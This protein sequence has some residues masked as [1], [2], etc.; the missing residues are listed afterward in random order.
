M[1][2][3]APS[4]LTPEEEE[5]R[6]WARYLNEGGEGLRD[7]IARVCPT[8][9]APPHLTPLID[10]MERC[11]L[12]GHQ[13]LAVSFPPRHGKTVT[14]RRALAWWLKARPADCC[15]Y[16]SRTADG[17]A[18]QSR[19]V[20]FLAMA[21]G[22]GLAKNHQ[23]DDNWQTT[24]GGGLFACGIDGMLTGNPITGLG[25]VDD[26]IKSRAEAES[27]AYR[28]RVWDFF[29]DVVMTRPEGPASIIVVHTR[30][31][32]DDLI[33]RLIQEGGWDVINL[34]AIA[35]QGDPIGRQE[36]EA[37]WPERFPVDRLLKIKQ[38]NEF[39]FDSLYQ[40]RPVPKGN[41]LFYGPPCYYDPKKT[42]LKGCHVLI[43]ADPAATAKTTAD[44]SAAV[45][46]AIRP[47]FDCPTIY[48]LD[49]Y[50]RQVEVPQQ[51]R[52]LLAFQRRNYGAK[53][54][55]EAV[56]GF[57]AVPQLLRDMAPGV[58]VGEITPKGDK[59]QRAERF[60]SAWN[61]SRV[62]LPKT[63]PYLPSAEVAPPWVGEFVREL[64]GF[65]GREGGQ[66]DQVDA[67]SNALNEIV[68][69]VRIV[70]TRRGAVSDGG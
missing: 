67:A 49:V 58:L 52:D 61:D 15:A 17:A 24:H 55:V 48:V 69:A 30:W 39:T 26:P 47:P 65:T 9:P 40:G 28:E 46:M 60:A 70:R 23:R 44:H 5:L 35:E 54:W 66:D 51:A 6:F 56:A 36:G 63:D 20:R 32:P 4:G 10:A 57:K 2:T 8:E 3:P 38:R 7:F 12:L 25:I 41:R 29:N 33:G 50:R 62:L 11:R 16:V 53:L 43:G 21:E 18:A 1:A 59:R 37:L 22:I 64:Q 42:D 14:L 68:G 27:E 19:K 34:P 45:A 13:R 31:N